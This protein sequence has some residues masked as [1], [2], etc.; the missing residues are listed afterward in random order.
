MADS[1]FR[2]PSGMGGLMRYDSE[3]KSHF[4]ISPAAVI[5]FAIAVIGFV[6]FLKAFFPLGVI[7]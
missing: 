3:Y 7:G 4:M 2:L 6:V 5:A 1:G